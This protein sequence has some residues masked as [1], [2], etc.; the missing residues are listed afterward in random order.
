MGDE[1]PFEAPAR[2]PSVVQVTDPRPA[3]RNLADRTR[4]FMEAQMR[5]E[6]PD[7]VARELARSID[8][9][10][11]RMSGSVPAQTPGALFEPGGPLRN[12]YGNA[13]IGRRN[14]VAPP[15][16]VYR[17]PDGRAWADAELGCLYEGPPGQVHGG[18]CAMILD[19]VLG[20]AAA[21]GGNAGMTVYLHTTF[22]RITRLGPVTVEA[23]TEQV[24]GRKATV[25]GYLADAS[26]VPCVEAEALFIMPRSQH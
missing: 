2:G 25:Q 4:A 1:P 24:D 7:D 9:L 20:E 13:V 6:L 11:E 23:W 17:T 12:D 5:A 21:A 15:L 22:R 18:Y 8:Q 14:P 19:Q 26:G 3:L 10:V 16:T